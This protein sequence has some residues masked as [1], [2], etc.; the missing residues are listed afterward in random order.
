MRSPG[1]FSRDRICSFQHFSTSVISFQF[2]AVGETQ[3][4]ILSA[5]QGIALPLLMAD[6]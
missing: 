6:G 2:F 1:F 3:S 5:V 4:R